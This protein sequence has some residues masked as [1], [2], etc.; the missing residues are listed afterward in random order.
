MDLQR[1]SSKKLALLI[2]AILALVG[3]AALEAFYALQHAVEIIGGIVVL[4]GA[5]VRPYRR[6]WT[7]DG[8]R[9]RS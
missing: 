7:S 9:V 8:R 5:K 4:G 6:G 2:V 3:V 1:L